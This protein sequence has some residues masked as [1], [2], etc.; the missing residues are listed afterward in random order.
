LTLNEAKVQVE[1]GLTIQDLPPRST[2]NSTNIQKN[3]Q[4]LFE[5][6]ILNMPTIQRKLNITMRGAI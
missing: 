5:A 3:V 4:V 2:I 1:N 6:V